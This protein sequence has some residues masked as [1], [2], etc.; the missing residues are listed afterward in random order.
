MIFGWPS[1]SVGTF[2][3]LWPY[4]SRVP[5]PAVL[6]K[7]RHTNGLPICVPL[8]R[9]RNCSAALTRTRRPNSQRCK[10]HNRRSDS[11]ITVSGWPSFG[12]GG[13][14]MSLRVCSRSI[15]LASAT[16]PHQI[17]APRS[18]VNG[19]ILHGI[20]TWPRLCVKSAESGKENGKR[21][22]LVEG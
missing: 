11:S 8:A 20:R 4:R 12:A 7:Y 15:S 5:S 14:P 22:S 21:F 17:S 16:L 10:S 6:K 18:C 9:L 1:S 3:A 13:C 2:P 19:M